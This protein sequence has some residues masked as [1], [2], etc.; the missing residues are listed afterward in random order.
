[1]SVLVLGANGLLGSNVL[2][3]CRRQNEAVVGTYHTT[4]PD[5]DVPCR[6]LDIR[7]ED[8]TAELLDELNPDLV[9]NCAAMTDVDGC[10]SAP[11][12][13][14][15]INGAAPGM[16]AAACADR[17]IDF[18]HVSTDYVFDGDSEAPYKEDSEP[19]PRQVYGKSK[20]AGE[21]AVKKHH[22]APTIARLSFVYGV[23]SGEGGLTGFPAWVRSRLHEESE[24]P[25]FT[26]QAVTPTRAG[27]AAITLLDLYDGDHTGTYHIAC[28]SCIT[29]Y[30]FGR[31]ICERMGASISLLTEGSM[32]DVDR[33][34][35][36]PKETCL[37]VDSLESTLGRAQPTL[38]ED[39][40]QISEMFE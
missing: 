3:E 6:E 4:A 26:D 40:E 16:I 24:V 37:A 14:M 38:T 34:A 2:T 29:P 7:D 10:E 27:Q 32:A 1:M 28:R 23:H 9:V 12:E 19:N 20:L 39:L 8:Q 25:L 18:T 13:A 22:P 11:D 17:G 5:I 21:R 31:Q 30:E 35:E 33:P 15:A 36:R